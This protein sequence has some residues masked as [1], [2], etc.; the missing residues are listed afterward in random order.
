MA[1]LGKTNH[2]R[3]LRSAP[4]GFYLDGGALGEILLPGGLIPPGAKVG[5]DVEVFLYRDSEDR[6]VATPQKPLAQVGEF[7]ALRV[8]AVNPRIGVFLDWGLDKD[9]LLPLREQTGPLLV[10]ERVIVKVVVD[11]RSQRIVASARLNRHLNLAPP[12]Y[13][14]G[15]PVRLLV[16]GET[17][18]GYNTIVE[19]AH[20]GLLYRSDLGQALTLGATF[21]GYVRRVRDDGKIDVALDRAGH[22]RVAS[23]TETILEKLRASGGRLPLH[24]GS[25]PEEIRAALGMS[26]KAF[27]QAIGVLYKSRQLVIE[28]YGI[29]LSAATR[30]E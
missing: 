28:Q 25:S 27:K 17:P 9:L 12:A 2:L 4:P 13:A 29:R 21:A 15:Q 26:K 23:L 5:G 11:E 16:S 1:L 7:A 8:V 10:G 30:P 24:D 18:L 14:E 20:S 22:Q 3:V 6:L 19:N